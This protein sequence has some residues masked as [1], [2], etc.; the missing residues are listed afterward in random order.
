MTTLDSAYREISSL[1]KDFKSGEKYYLSKEYQ[2]AEVRKDFIDKFL[3]A[4]GWDVLHNEQKNPYEQEVKVEKGV[5]IAG[6]Q[7]KA[8]YSFALTP[9]YRDPKL[10]L[11][12][13]KPFQNLY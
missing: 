4:F 13:K 11:E 12:A 8:D 3:M 6:A 1:V 2:E 10:F 5:S 7:K 9:N